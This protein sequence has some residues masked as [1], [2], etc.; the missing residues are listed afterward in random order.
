MTDLH[1]TLYELWT[2]L[3]C[4][5]CEEPLQGEKCWN[6]DCFAAG[7]LIPLPVRRARGMSRR[8]AASTISMI[9]PVAADRVHEI[10][11]IGSGNIFLIPEAD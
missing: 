1:S 5:F 10:R 6:S 9:I 8:A 3:C 7:L 4:T 2:E 11:E